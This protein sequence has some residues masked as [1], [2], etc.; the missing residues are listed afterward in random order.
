MADKDNFGAAPIFRP[1]FDYETGPDGNFI[2]RDTEHRDRLRSVGIL[3]DSP[4]KPSRRTTNAPFANWALQRGVDF[5]GCV[6][7]YRTNGSTRP[8]YTANLP[9]QTVLQVLSEFDPELK[10]IEEASRLPEAR[11]PIQYQ[12]RGGWFDY[13]PHRAFLQNVGEVLQWRAA[14]K[15]ELG[16]NAAA[17]ADIEF[18]LRLAGAYRME[19]G[20][21]P[22]LARQWIQLE[23]LQPVWEGLARHRWTPIEL[24]RLQ[25]LLQINILDDYGPA[26]REQMVLCAHFW[27]VFTDPD[28]SI[29]RP[30]QLPPGVLFA[31]KVYPMGWK[32]R[33][34]AGLIGLGE[35][36]FLPIIDAPSNRVFP[37]AQSRLNA[38][39]RHAGVTMDP[40]FH[41]VFGG[42]G[43]HPLAD[44]PAHFA[45]A[46]ASLNEAMVA[47]A[48][49]R[50]R[51]DHGCWPQ[52]LELLIADSRE[53]LPHDP[54]TGHPFRYRVLPNDRFLLYS[55]GWNGRDDG[56]QTVSQTP[57]PQTIPQVNLYEADWVWTYP[58]K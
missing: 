7:F 58:A 42:P 56:G 50:W 8:L 12:L 17:L 28:K 54:I 19:L 35:D 34:Q 1:L 41:L 36:T 43:T 6:E 16:E 33:N 9:A 24:Q 4:G 47:C 5:T 48:L 40:F 21:Y 53:P 18:A 15:L 10:E 29:L 55:V 52:T 27:N 22:R 23:A 3:A 26:I 30:W 14:A 49:E 44:A 46:Q 20:I 37:V 39:I 32:Y 38:A 45:H 11:F 25:R 13:A 2:W 31:S 51:Q 57:G